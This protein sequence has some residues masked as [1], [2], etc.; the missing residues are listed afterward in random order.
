MI[1]THPRFV[2]VAAGALGV[3]AASIPIVVHTTPQ[4][5][6]APDAGGSSSPSL[7]DRWNNLSTMGKVAVVGAGAAVVLLVATRKR[8]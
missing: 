8:R 4:A 3:P 1:I 2:R 6:G 7:M 5:F